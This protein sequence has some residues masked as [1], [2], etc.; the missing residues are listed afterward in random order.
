MLLVEPDHK[1]WE[2]D[3]DG[4]GDVDPAENGSRTARG[5]YMEGIPE[6]DVD[7]TFLNDPRDHSVIDDTNDNS[8]ER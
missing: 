5:W 2:A 3:A 8:R 6:Q 1:K 7:Q 4:E